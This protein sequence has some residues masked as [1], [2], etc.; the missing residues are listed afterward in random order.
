ME[1]FFVHE[2]NILTEAKLK[3]KFQLNYNDK[4]EDILL[5]FEIIKMINYDF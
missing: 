1:G 5:H 2:K 4:N 3:L